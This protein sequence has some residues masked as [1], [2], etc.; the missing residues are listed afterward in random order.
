M[1]SGHQRRV[2]IERI[3]TPS[4]GV[5]R[6]PK[7]SFLW[8]RPPRI[9][10][11]ELSRCLLRLAKQGAA[12]KRRLFGHTNPDDETVPVRRPPLLLL[13]WERWVRGQMDHVAAS[14]Y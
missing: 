7:E 2:Q 12:T 6:F 3:G 5:R 4:D 8:W 1:V 9:F 11:P 10:F 14:S 13:C